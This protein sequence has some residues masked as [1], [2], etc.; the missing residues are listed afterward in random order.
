MT[1]L[2]DINRAC[3]YKLCI[4]DAPK[5]TENLLKFQGIKRK[6]FNENDFFLSKNTTFKDNIISKTS[7][8]GWNSIAK[9][10]H[11]ISEGRQ[12]FKLKIK[13]LHSDKQGLVFG[14]SQA[15]SFDHSAENLV[16]KVNA[17]GNTIQELNPSDTIYCVIDIEQNECQFMFNDIRVAVFSNLDKLDKKPA[18]FVVL[19]LYSHNKVELVEID[20][21]VASKN[22]KCSR[23]HIM[24]KTDVYPFNYSNGG[25]YCDNCKESILL[26]R[27]ALVKN[28]IH[29]FRCNY[30]CNYDFCKKCQSDLF[31]LERFHPLQ[32]DIDQM[33]EPEDV[34][35]FKWKIQGDAKLNQTNDHCQISRTLDHTTAWN[36]LWV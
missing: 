20:T 24:L 14:F 9:L 31:N 18:C 26:N 30:N 25:I 27:E 16:Q 17:Q 29:W 6:I 19:N 33:A 5:Q 3:D 36:D 21:T 2:A 28:P 12:I 22:I 10:L 4:V 23:G 7:S 8:N 34:D 1:D 35:K 32:K 11:P 15:E 13:E